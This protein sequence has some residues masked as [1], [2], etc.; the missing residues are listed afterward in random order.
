MSTDD[1]I[2]I[3]TM[4]LFGATLFGAFLVLAEVKSGHEE[5]QAA[6]IEN[7]AAHIRAKKQATLNYY[8]QTLDRLFKL[9][10]ELHFPHDRDGDAIAVI[11]KEIKENPDSDE[12]VDRTN[13]IHS[14][15][16]FW[17]LTAVAIK[18]E[19]F[20]EEFFRDILET[21]FLLLE[22]HYRPFMQD[23]RKKHGKN[24]ENLYIKIAELAE[25]WN[26]QAS[27]SLGADAMGRPEA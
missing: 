19:V 11:L 23:A 14:Y 8:T 7:Q 17:E 21:H 22:K 20:D 26:R 13:K 18:Q 9:Q 12:S 25:D 10:S 1:W 3:A 16:A 4:L 5:N 15:L 2:A 24:T 6:H 27:A